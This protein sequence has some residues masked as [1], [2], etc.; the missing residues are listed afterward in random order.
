VEREL[1]PNQPT[2]VELVGREPGTYEVET[3]DPELL[4]SKIT[5]R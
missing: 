2:T 5:V 4:L 1:R 3:H